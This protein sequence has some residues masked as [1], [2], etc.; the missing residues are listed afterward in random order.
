MSQVWPIKEMIFFHLKSNKLLLKNFQFKTR[1]RNIRNNSEEQ[2]ECKE[3][4]KT[5]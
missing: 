5:I 3:S 4:V 2:N 1:L